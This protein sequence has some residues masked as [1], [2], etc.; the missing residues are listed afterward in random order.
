MYCVLVICI[1]YVFLISVH[2]LSF[3]FY[4][5][6]QFYLLYFLFIVIET[7][8]ENETYFLSISLNKICF[9]KKINK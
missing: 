2:L 6:C 8:N 5:L 4:F 9:N 7:I 3:I 1:V